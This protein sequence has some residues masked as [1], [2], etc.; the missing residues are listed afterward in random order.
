[1]KKFFTLVI[2]VIAPLC[3]FSAV[4]DTFTVKTEN[5]VEM[6]FT[7]TSEGTVNTVKTGNNCIAWDYKGDVA[8]PATVTNN[9]IKYTVTWIGSGSFSSCAMKSISLPP[10]I[11]KMLI[12]GIYN[13]RYLTAL[14]IPASVESIVEGAISMNPL[15]SL[16]VESGN[17]NY[18]TVDNVLFDKDKTTFYNM[19]V[20][21]L[22]LLMQ[23][24]IL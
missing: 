15:T 16:I 8:V 2:G 19:H 14:N 13:C 21:C 10:T 17:K 1:M 24:Q 3:A 12:G 18:V 7:V 4:G 22:P 5:D 11:T 20:G 9:G 6:S 23:F